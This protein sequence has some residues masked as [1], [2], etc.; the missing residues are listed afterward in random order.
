VPRG[1]RQVIPRPPEA[2]P[3][4]AAPWAVLPAA[5]RTLTLATVRQRS[6]SL[7]PPEPFL[8]PHP[9][10]VAAAVLVPLFAGPDDDARMVLTR[11][12]DTMPSHQGQVAF[13]GGK[14]DRSVDR[15]P[16]DTAVRE[17]Y[18]EIGLA[19]DAVEIVAEL[20][21]VG[22]AVGQFVMTPFVGVLAPDARLVA[23]PHEVARVFDVSLAELLDPEVYRGEIWRLGAEMRLMHF[24]EV[25]GETIW[26][27]TARILAEL[28]G[29]WTATRFREPAGS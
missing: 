8:P 2:R 16:R 20:P 4:G 10:S 14:V 23:H 15:T 26:G 13:P 28:L 22:T 3:A 12:P 11:R 9:D 7:P 24:F 29:A 18:E 25:D 19:P 17:A 6:A 1:G 21:S 5:D 27:A